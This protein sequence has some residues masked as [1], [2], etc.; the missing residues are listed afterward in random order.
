MLSS[1]FPSYLKKLKQKPI[2]QQLQQK[3][4]TTRHAI[5]TSNNLAS[6]HTGPKFHFVFLKK[7]YFT[8]KLAFCGPF[9]YVKWNFWDIKWTFDLVCKLHRKK[10]HT[11][12]LC[13]FFRPPPPPCDPHPISKNRKFLRRI[14]MRILREWCANRAM[15][16]IMDV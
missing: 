7:V 10:L 2:R 11:S 8:W 12:T 1:H 13:S 9:F 3:K 15:C 5:I 14:M 4:S 16:A 6:C